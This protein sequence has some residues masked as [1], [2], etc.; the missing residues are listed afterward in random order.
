MRAHMATGVTRMLA[1]LGIP[2]A[3]EALE[4]L[5][6]SSDAHLAEQARQAMSPPS[7]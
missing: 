7:A 6:R 2:E 1:Q 4:L 3:R 5:A